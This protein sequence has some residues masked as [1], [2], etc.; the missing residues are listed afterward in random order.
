MIAPAPNGITVYT[1]DYCPY[2][3]SAKRL[4]TTLRL[5]FQEVDVTGDDAARN[6]LVERTGRRTVPQIFIGSASIGGFTDLD[7]LQK[8]GGLQPL[9]DAAGIRRTGEP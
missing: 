1:T 8:A 6:A 7:A 3:T 9:L 5:D 4:L 2:C